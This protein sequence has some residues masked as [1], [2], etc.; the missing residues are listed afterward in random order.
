MKDVVGMTMKDVVGMTMKDEVGI[1]K[2]EV[3]TMKGVVGIT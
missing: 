2:D 3:V 1:L